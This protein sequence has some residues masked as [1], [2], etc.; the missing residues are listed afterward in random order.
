M[1]RPL[2]RDAQR[3]GV[4]IVTIELLP[5][6]FTVCQVSRISEAVLAEPFSFFARTDEELSLVCP[7]GKAPP[8]AE[9]AER[10]WRCLRVAGHLD[11]SLIGILAGIASCLA[12]A[13]IPIYAVST[14]NT[15]YVLVQILHEKAALQALKAAGYDI[16]L[17]VHIIG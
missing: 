8:E 6:E 11:F 12:Q 1:E 16:L 2:R 10:G 14:Y 3:T 4:E 7:S 13:R 15:D 9:K 17:P 5:M